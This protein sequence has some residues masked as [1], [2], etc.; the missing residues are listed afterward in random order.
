MKKFFLH[1]VFLLFI[2]A[3]AAAQENL[4]T[5]DST[6]IQLS[7]VKVEVD[8]RGN[9]FKTVRMDSLLMKTSR[10]K[11]LAD[12]L[13]SSGTVYMKQ[14]APGQL[15]SI[16]MRGSNT[17]QVQLLW[18]GFNL[19]NL[20]LGQTDFSMVP[21]SA[22]SNIEVNMG[23]L[24]ATGGNGVVA[25]AISLE[26]PMAEKT[27]QA[28]LQL[29]TQV[30][31]F[32]KYSADAGFAHRGKKHA[33]SIRPFYFNAD[34]RYPYRNVQGGTSV[35]EHAQSKMYGTLA[36]VQ[37]YSPKNTFRFDA[38]LQESH[39]D[40]PA[41]LYE[42]NSQAGQTDRNLRFTLGHYRKK[43]GLF[44]ENRIG[45]FYDRLDYENPRAA[46]ASGLKLHNLVG[47]TIG[48]WARGESSHKVK[49]YAS[50]A[51]ADNSNYETDGKKM[52]RASLGYFFEGQ[53]SE[54]YRGRVKFDL[55]EE[56]NNGVFSIPV[57]QLGASGAYVKDF[58]RV[59]NVFTANVNA[60]TVY[61]FPALNDLYWYPGGNPDLKPEKGGSA[62]LTL[63]WNMVSKSQRILNFVRVNFT[64][65][66]RYM[67]DWIMWQPRGV[68]W[69]PQN[70][71]EVWSRGNETAI[72][73]QFGRKMKVYAKTLFNYTLSTI[74]KSLIDNDQSIGRQLIYTPMYNG[75]GEAGILY[76]GFSLSGNMAYYGYRYTS[77]DNY[78]YL[79]PFYLLGA[80][81]TWTHGF[82]NVLV[83]VFISAEN[84]LNENY[85]WVAQRP[86]LPRNYTVGLSFKWI[87]TKTQTIQ[88]K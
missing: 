52:L 67:Y 47:E 63:E 54:K 86:A 87:K 50:V 10:G 66:Q 17:S 59:M 37:S 72:T 40:L 36:S 5:P 11:T 79:D 26:N 1:I 23:A 31:S 22:F 64:H 82:K 15:S 51:T 73:V 16:S 61:R 42:Q 4:Y 25:G 57:V 19:N 2:S 44:N 62:N 43:Y 29:G 70:L 48:N 84:L 18:N 30:G 38:W 68:Y 32:G 53:W 58:R 81:A 77:S 76:K 6:S 78:E 21:A 71:Q 49:A 88:T 83:D 3:V 27:G 39:R 41:T 14:Y 56:M 75:S 34:N 35:M 80:R 13:Q 60:G 8:N 65:Y 24:G 12:V 45:Y 74:Q 69:S 20:S 9:G 55:K 28:S 46:L 33:V 7:T 85:Y